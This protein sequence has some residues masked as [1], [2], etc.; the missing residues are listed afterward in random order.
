[1]ASA[2]RSRWPVPGVLATKGKTRRHKGTTMSKDQ[3]KA[4]AAGDAVVPPAGVEMPTQSAGAVSGPSAA[5]IPAAI[6]AVVPWVFAALGFTAGL[7]TGMSESPVGATAVG[8][9]FGLLGG[10]GLLTLL[11]RA[12]KR[13]AGDDQDDARGGGK[14]DKADGL[15]LSPA[16]VRRVAPCI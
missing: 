11:G 12:E 9:L 1:R 10:G 7:F 5:A 8:A 13:A 14:G 6:P 15:T 16:A 4:N 2:G 3:P